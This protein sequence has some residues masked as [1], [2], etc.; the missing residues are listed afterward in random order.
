MTQQHTP[1]KGFRLTAARAERIAARGPVVRAELRRHPHAFPYEYTRG[2]GQWQVSWFKGAHVGPQLVQVYIDDASGK[3]TAVWTGFQVAWT[4][5]RGYPGAFGRMANA[6]YIWLPLCFLF[7][8][9]FVRWRRLF[10]R[11]S[12]SLLHLDLLM[13]LGLSISLAFF[14]H[15]NIGMSVPLVYPFLVYL[16]VRL[17]L[18]ASGRGGP[19][20]PLDSSVPLKW[21]MGATVVLF[22]LRVAINVIN[23]NVIDVGFAGV[24]GSHRLLHGQ[25]LYGGWPS[26]ISQGDTY[27]PFTYYAYLPFT[28]IF[29]WSG[30]WDTLPAAHAAAIAFDL[31]TLVGLYL[32]GLKLRRPTLGALL[33]WS[34]VSYPF[35]LFTLSSNSNDTLVAAVVLAAVLALG[36]PPGRGF[37]AALAGLTK[38]APFGLVPLFARGL[39][40]NLPRWRALLVFVSVCVATV[41]A[42]L[43]PVFITGNFARLWHDSVAYQATRPA[44]FSIWGLYGGL[45]LEQHV[46]QG[47]AVLLAVVVAF[48]P[49]QRTMIEVAALGAAVL[50]AI[51]L[52]VT[53]WFYTYIVWFLPLGLV[54]LLGARPRVP[55]RLDEAATEGVAEGEPRELEPA[56]PALL[57]HARGGLQQLLDRGRAQRPVGGDEHGVEPGI[58]G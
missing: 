49:R 3:V 36:S 44:P 7:V 23:S 33:A 54:G 12:W 22:G 27:G 5:A 50:I 2:Q 24:V 21:L 56:S 28:A 42:A 19:R 57:A 34:W 10:R 58:V 29:G 1:P 16:L 51:Q 32:V 43:A 4:M 39:G 35:T 9:P 20:R 53:Y 25:T 52:G 31:L 17:L 8:V 26:N 6:L 40:P 41:A 37:L 46:V 13:L 38:F 18:L 45:S 11:S 15:A 48:R 55:E 30:T 14:N 47:L